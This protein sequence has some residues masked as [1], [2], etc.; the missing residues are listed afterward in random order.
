M[1]EPFTNLLFEYPGADIIIRSRDTHHFRVLK[2]YII[3]NSAV[4]DELIRNAIG[5]PH[6][7]HDAASLPVVQLPENG[8]ILHSLFTFV[9][10]VIPRLPSTTDQSMELLSVAQKYQMDSVLA[11][12]RLSIARHSPPSTQRDSALHMYSLAH[13][14]GLRQEV[15]QAA[16][17]I[18]HYPLNI[19]NLEDRFDTMSGATL[20][21]LWKY[22]EKVRPVLASDLEGFRTSGARGIL[23]GVS[24]VELSSS[25]I[26]RW[27]DDYIASI[28]NAPNLFD[29][30]EFNTIRASHV[31]QFQ[32]GCSCGSIS[33]QTIRNFWEAL[34]SVLN[35][36]FE[37]VSVID[38]NELLTRLMFLSGRVNSCSRA[39]T[40][41][42]PGPSQLDHVC[43]WSLGFTGREPRRPIVRPCQ[44][45][46]P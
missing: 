29:V 27:L 4:L 35:R 38:V 6:S 1:D 42:F 34:A 17:I 25:Q 12:I 2:S 15:L 24:C 41:G 36:S 3:N 26:P 31:S 45:P 37:K 5:F 11:L 22:S 39:R 21:E 10:P 33:S 19:E 32:N 43:P 20:Y 18:F 23:T 9:F 28:G 7:A 44:L 40:R 46:R 30:F 14:Y 16:R 13:K 8:A